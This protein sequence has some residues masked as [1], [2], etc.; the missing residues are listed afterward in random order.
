MKSVPAGN[1]YFCYRVKR[2]YLLMGQF[3]DEALKPF[4]LARSQWQIL[5]QV[6]KAGKL[7]QKE[8]QEIMKV[9]AATLTGIIDVLE[10]KGWLERLE[11]PLDKRVK[12]LRFTEIG[13]EKWKKVPDPVEMVEARMFRGLNESESTLIQNNIEL[14]IGNLEERQLD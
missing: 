5:S 13:Q 1:R 2:L 3:I 6:H 9:E 4:G 7:T 11:N 10:R 14:M 8:L 12:V